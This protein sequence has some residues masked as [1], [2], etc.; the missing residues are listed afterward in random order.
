MSRGPC[1]CDDG[2]VNRPIAYWVKRLDMSLE[3]LL[4]STISRLSLTRRQWQLL[5]ALSA[6]ALTPEEIDDVLNPFNLADRGH[7]QEREMAAL[8]RKGLVFLLDDRLGLSPAGSALLSEISELMEATRLEL[9]AGIGADEYA[10]AISV[11]ERMS[12]TADRL[13]KW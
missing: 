9:T 12:Q 2:L 3:A 4:D 10:I 1:A 13:T 7:A 11:L 6:E 5:S 8:V